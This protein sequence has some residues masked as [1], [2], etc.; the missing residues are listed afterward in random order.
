MNGMP[1]DLARAPRRAREK[2]TDRSKGVP[3]QRPGE[4]QARHRGFK[5]GVEQRI[6]IALLNLLKE[7]CIQERDPFYVWLIPG[8]QAEEVDLSLCAIAQFDPQSISPRLNELDLRV[9][10]QAHDS[11]NA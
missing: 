10:R 1:R 5:P 8:S 2:T 11:F 3:G 7:R 9:G 4:V 6:S